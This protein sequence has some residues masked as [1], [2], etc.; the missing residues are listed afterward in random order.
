MREAF[1]IRRWRSV[2]KRIEHRDH[3]D[4]R[5]S[6]DE[7][8]LRLCRHGLIGAHRRAG[9]AGKGAFDYWAAAVEAVWW[10]IALDDLLHSLYNF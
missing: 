2:A 3:P 5:M 4:A 10:A 1:R 7:W 9:V 6:S 8:R